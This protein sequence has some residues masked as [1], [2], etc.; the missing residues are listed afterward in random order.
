MNN[1]SK[2][3]IKTIHSNAVVKEASRHHYGGTIGIYVIS[4]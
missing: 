3:A 2:Q 4:L 1:G